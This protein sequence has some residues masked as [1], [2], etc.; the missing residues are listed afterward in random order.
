MSKSTTEWFKNKL[1]D[2][3]ND[4]VI[5]IDCRKTVNNMKEYEEHESHNIIDIFRENSSLDDSTVMLKKDILK[6]LE[7]I[8]DENEG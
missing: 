4:E 6:I 8:M 1:K 2:N 5:C 7:K 3:N